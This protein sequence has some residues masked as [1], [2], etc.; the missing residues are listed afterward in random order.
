MIH[1]RC[2]SDQPH[3]LFHQADEG[4]LFRKALT[5][6]EEQLRSNHIDTGVIIGLTTPHCM[7][8]PPFGLT[9]ENG[10]YYDSETIHRLS[11][12]TLHGEVAVMTTEQLMKKWA[13]H[14]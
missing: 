11:F 10:T 6:L 7:M 3:S 8:Q 9:D 2:T 14:E 1:I 13:N 5:N 12:A 4:H